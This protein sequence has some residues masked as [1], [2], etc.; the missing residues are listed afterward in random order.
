MTYKWQKCF[1]Y[2]EFRN[3]QD[4]VI[5]KIIKA[6]ESD[7]RFV[8]AE[9]P[10]GAGKSAIGYT[11]GKYFEDYYYVTA[12]KLLQSQLSADFGENGV[13]SGQKPMIELKGRNAYPCDYYQ[14]AL[15]D[16][17]FTPPLNDEQINRYQ[18][19]IDEETN[20]ARGEC[21]RKGKSSLKYCKNHNICA[22]LKQLD[23][24]TSNPAT[25][26]NFS[27]FIYQTQFVP[28]NW[29]ARNLLIIDE[30]HGTE[31]VLMDYVSFKL[32]DLSYDFKL[33]K[34]D[35]CEEY[36]IFFEEIGLE[37]DLKTKLKTAVESGNS[38]NEE[39]WSKQLFKYNRFR[40]SVQ[41]HEWI[42]NYEEKQLIK[43][44]GKRAQKYREVELKPLFVSDFA[45]DILFGMADKVLM[46]SA[47]I[48]SVN[49]MCE[50]L[51]IDKND[52]YSIRTDSDFP[53]ENRPI[54]YK[55]SG[56]MS[57]QQKNDTIPKMMM[58]IE[59][60][61]Q[62]Y[63]DKKGIIHTHNFEISNYIKNNA[64]KNLF[65]RLF[66]QE[67]FNNKDE[68]LI[69][70]SESE[71]G[72][73]VAPAMHEGLSLDNDKS[74]FQIIAKVPYPGLGNNPQLKRRMEISG[75]YYGYLSCHKIVQSAGRSVR[76]KKDWADTY[77]LDQGFK[78]FYH[79]Y[80]HM[81]PKWFKEAIIW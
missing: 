62:K 70:H 73:I 24:A 16:S 23:K 53:V 45:E 52:V 4:E 3:G 47:T 22:Y 58:D 34:Y 25:L 20:C 33:P 78:S 32:N 69:K 27:S 60:I 11:V 14:Y 36:L 29:N 26:M 43:T 13:W 56:N 71:N 8:I 50:S 31:Q 39:Y 48:L 15:N 6:F 18:K 76:S 68:M 10:T 49:V 54:Y 28:M 41:K 12:Q 55:P 61:C 40:N 79:R 81:L 51:G 63:Q 1:P 46:M 21:K 42:P 9:M 37:D 59:K 35:N 38:E 80:K 67:D 30:A 19:L 66:L 2:P 7:K 44:S 72:I 5:D 64:S 75:E 65:K 17:K 74:R 57:Y 77:I